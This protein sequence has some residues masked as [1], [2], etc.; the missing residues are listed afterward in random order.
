ME[1]LIN[2]TS[3]FFESFKSFG[4][5]IMSALPGIIGAILLILLGWLVARL[6]ARLITKLLKALKFNELV[7]KL[8]AIGILKHLNVSI[9]PSEI[10]GK[11]VFWIIFLLFV[12]T[13]TETLGWSVVASEITSLIRFIPNL[14]I[15]IIIFIIGLY[16]ANFIKSLI[17]ASFSSLGITSGKIIS[18]IA[19]YIIMV[20]VSLTALKQ[21]GIN[22]SFIDNNITIVVAILVGAFALSFAISSKVV[23][24][25][26]LA[27]FYSKNNFSVGQKIK[28]ADVSG[29]VEKI[30][31]TH[32]VLNCDNKKTV[33][34]VSILLT[35]KVEIIDEPDVEHK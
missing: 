12:V 14:F 6:I 33:F 28:V 1:S 4:K 19:F 5:Q 10:V 30:D 21:T 18:E 27:G 24:Q 3:V 20:V 11:F 8:N 17:N 31:S 15:G 35:E 29:I 7:N 34:P 26:I 16:I 13:A 2:W 23:L 25:N 32:L 22:T 9:S